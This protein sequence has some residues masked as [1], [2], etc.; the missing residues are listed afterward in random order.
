M[1]KQV[2]VGS[3]KG[4]VG[5]T[6]VAVNLACALAGTVSTVVLVDL[7]AQSTATEWREAG[8]L[9]IT[10]GM[11]AQ[12]DIHTGSKSVLTYP[13]KPVLKLKNEAFRER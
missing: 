11:Q 8:H 1:T 2:A 13:V 4:S 9:P 6:T 5:K 10:P 3:L 7:D 12:V